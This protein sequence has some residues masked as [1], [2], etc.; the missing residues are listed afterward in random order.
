MFSLPRELTNAILGCIRF[1]LQKCLREW[2]DENDEVWLCEDELIKQFQMFSEGW[3]KAYGKLLPR[4]RGEVTD[5]NGVVHVTRW[6][7]PRN[8]IQRMIAEGSI[9]QL[10]ITNNKS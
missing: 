3:M 9:K 5:E 1:T 6:T 4:T 8:K 7:Y 10:R 2:K